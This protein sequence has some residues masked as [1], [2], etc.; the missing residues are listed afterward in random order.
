MNKNELT[1][2]FSKGK[3]GNINIKNRIVRSATTSGLAENGYISEREIKIYSD[4]AQGGTGLIVTGGVSV[5]ISG[6][7]G[8]NQVY[9]HDDKYISGHKKLVNAVHEYSDVKIA[10]QLLHVGRQGTDPNNPPIAPSAV[11]NE[12]TNLIPR[13]LTLKE[14]RNITK[15]FVDAGCRAFESG[16]DMIQVHAAHDYL[17]NNFLSPYSNRRNDEFGGNTENRTKILVDIR[18]Q[19]RDEVGK[20]F[21]VIV[22]LQT[23][24]GFPYGIDLNEAKKIAQILV[25]AKYDA[26]EPSGGSRETMSVGKKVTPSYSIKKPEEENYFL[27][28]AKQLKTIEYCCPVILVGGIRNPLAAEKFIQEKSADY[29]SMSRPLIREP[30]L[31]N[32]WE[33]GDLEPAHCISCNLCYGTLYRGGLHC[34]V[35]KRQERRR[36]KDAKRK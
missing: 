23:I 1:H 6:L 17:L 4:L 34:V 28:N 16:Y 18:D 5:D 25:D 9:L 32:R 30:N 24:D 20:E 7:S 35:K 14:I 22:K 27:I 26:I 11:L 36:R 10:L 15:K 3:I 21:P 29:I 33:I 31:P 13:E 8:V 2:L 12:F 19:L